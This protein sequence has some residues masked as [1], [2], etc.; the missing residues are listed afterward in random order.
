L[1]CFVWVGF[2][3]A[4]FVHV[5]HELDQCQIHTSVYQVWL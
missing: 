1:N 3:Y 5:L 4:G 2:V